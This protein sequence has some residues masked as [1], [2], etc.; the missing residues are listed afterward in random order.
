MN[1]RKMREDYAAL[2]QRET[3]VHEAYD[4]LK[5]KEKQLLAREAALNKREEVARNKK[6]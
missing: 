5:Q 4:K 1:E 2:K 3:A 6:L